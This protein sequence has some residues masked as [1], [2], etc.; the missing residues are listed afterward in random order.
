MSKSKR[1]TIRDALIANG[2]KPIENLDIYEKIDDFDVSYMDT[3]ATLKSFM[4]FCTSAMYRYKYNDEQQDRCEAD[5]EDILHEIELKPLKSAF[6]GY[7]IYRQ[8]RD[9]RQERRRCKDENGML[10]P[11]MEF[12]KKRPEFLSEMEIAQKQSDSVKRTLQNR[13]YKVRGT[14]LKE[15]GLCEDGS[16]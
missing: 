9:I 7:R 12:L 1:V 15:M 13:M 3:D 10:F 11:L 2:T 8:I 5:Q 16:F 6:N 14:V 4:T